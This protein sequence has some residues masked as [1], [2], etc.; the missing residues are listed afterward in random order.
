MDLGALKTIEC[1]VSEGVANVVLNQP[2]RGNPIDAVS[3]RELK[4]LV[5]A[6]SERNDVRVVLLGARG[7]MFSVGGDIKAFVESRAALP[8]I[9][10]EWTADL[11]GAIARLMRMRAPVIAAV[12][13]SVGG[14]SVS[15]VAAADIVY[16]T[17]G[18]KFASGFAQIG[19]SADSGSTV[20]LTQRMG[21]ARAKRFLL[22][23]EVID[24]QEAKAAGLVDFVVSDG[25]A[26]AQE[27]AAMARKLAAGA[28]LALGAI[29]QLMLRS[30]TQGAETQMEDEAQTLAAIV[31]SDDTWEGVQAFLA[32]R[33]PVF[34]GR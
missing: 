23:S 31:R 34:G 32:R 11:H 20:T 27:S 19:F 22:L 12:H 16:A 17:Q 2:E 1:T 26:L 25:A 14:G 7:R 9:V 13:G 3:S 8:A 10:K 30:R 21:W 15:L 18:A 5:N 28:P 4:G 29:K 6:L 24:A 33:Q